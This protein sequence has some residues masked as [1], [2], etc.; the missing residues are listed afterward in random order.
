M[1]GYFCLML[2]AP[3]GLFVPYALNLPICDM[4]TVGAILRCFLICVVCYFGLFCT[5]R[6]MFPYLQY[7]I[8]FRLF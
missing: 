6:S 2:I 8:Y 3:T 7:F 1:Y 4:L 5:F